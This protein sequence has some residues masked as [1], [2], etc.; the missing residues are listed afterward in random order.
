LLSRLMSTPHG[1]RQKRAGQKP[2]RRHLGFE[3]LESRLA[4]ALSASLTNGL[5]S[6]AFTSAGDAAQVTHP[7]GSIQVVDAVA[8]QVAGSF[9]D[10]GVESITAQGSG[11]A[12]QAVTF[13]GTVGLTGELITSGVADVTLSGSYTAK[14]AELAASDSFTLAAGGLL[15]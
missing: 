1:A 13:T 7:A 10:T 9:P 5:L 15:S 14:S 3:E 12:G 8:H 6:I 4:P 2:W 11:A